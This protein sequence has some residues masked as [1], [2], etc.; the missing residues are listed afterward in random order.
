M[1][2]TLDEINTVDKPYLLIPCI[3]K[4][5]VLELESEQSK[6]SQVFGVYP[7]GNVR[8]AIEASKWVYKDYGVKVRIVRNNALSENHHATTVST[9]RPSYQ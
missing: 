5:N 9:R 1:L 3:N 6:R 7:L 2:L 8:L 4:A